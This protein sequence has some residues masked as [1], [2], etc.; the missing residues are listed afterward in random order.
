MKIALAIGGALIGVC[1]AAGA[2]CFSKY[3]KGTDNPSIEGFCD[4]VKKFC[5]KK[6]DI[7]TPTEDAMEE[8]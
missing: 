3:A 8:F 4:A 5:E 1:A 7:P 2:I 6:S